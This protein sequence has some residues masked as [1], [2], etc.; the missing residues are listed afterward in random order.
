[1]ATF[2]DVKAIENKTNYWIDYQRS[3]VNN[4]AGRACYPA[5]KALLVFQFL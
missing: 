1:M 5:A 2:S 4:E 3:S